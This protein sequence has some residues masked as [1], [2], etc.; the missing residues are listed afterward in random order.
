MDWDGTRDDDQSYFWHQQ[1]TVRLD[2]DC[3]KLVP[4]KVSLGTGTLENVAMNQN[5]LQQYFNRLG[6][7]LAVGGGVCV[8]LLVLW[9]LGAF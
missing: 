5:N 1:A 9:L 4:N 6:P 3:D 2:Q 8:I 7:I